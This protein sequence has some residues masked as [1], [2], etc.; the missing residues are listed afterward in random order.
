MGGS[1]SRKINPGDV[2]HLFFLRG[3]VY[4]AVTE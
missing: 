4:G 3:G 2:T 1:A